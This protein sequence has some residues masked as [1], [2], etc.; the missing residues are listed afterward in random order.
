MYFLKFISIIKNCQNL[1]INK[2]QVQFDDA[3]LHV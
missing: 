2:I 1:P 3:K